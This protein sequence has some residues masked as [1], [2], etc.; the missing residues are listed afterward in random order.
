MTK[1]L[2]AIG[3]YLAILPRESVRM[4]KHLPIKPL[5]VAFAGIER[6][7]GIMTLKHRTISPQAR[8][9]IDA[10]RLMAAAAMK[11]GR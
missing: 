9:F 1:Q 6:S 10:M 5:N 8:L 2:L 7:I 3:R 4:A 11:P